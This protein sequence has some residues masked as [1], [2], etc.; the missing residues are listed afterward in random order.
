MEDNYYET[1][2]EQEI[3]NFNV[4][5]VIDYIMGTIICITI[6]V[7]LVLNFIH[8]KECIF[9]RRVEKAVKKM[10]DEEEKYRH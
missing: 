2:L 3:D 1:Q 10:R 6:I 9:Q 7:C 5:T 8:L 4:N